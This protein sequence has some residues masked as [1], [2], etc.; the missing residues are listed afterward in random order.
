L[1]TRIER[2]EWRAILADNLK[3][4]VRHPNYLNVV[5]RVGHNVAGGAVAYLQIH[6]GSKS[7]IPQMVGIA[8]SRLEAG[9]HARTQ[10]DL[11]RIRYQDGCAFK[12]VQKFILK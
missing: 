3:P 7:S 10:R 4:T 12:D 6:D 9:A 1:D 8:A 5:V 11:T 2:S